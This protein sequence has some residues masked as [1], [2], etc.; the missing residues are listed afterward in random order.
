MDEDLYDEYVMRK[1]FFQYSL[2]I[3]KNH[4]G[5]VTTLVVP[6]PTRN[7]NMARPRPKHTTMTS[8][9]KKKKVERLKSSLR[10]EN[11]MS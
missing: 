9:L 4:A 5:S 11:I 2:Q 1:Y 10:R 8:V 7:P 3:L 6:S